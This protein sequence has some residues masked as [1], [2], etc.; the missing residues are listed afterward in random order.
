MSRFLN[1][2]DN[3]GMLIKVQW[4]IIAGLLVVTAFAIDGLRRAPSSMDLHI[5]PDLTNGAVVHPGEV[6]P[7]NVY[8]FTLA[9]WQQVNRW[10]KNGQTDFGTQ[11]FAMSPYLTPSC[12]DHLTDHMNLRAGRG[13]LSQRTRVLSEMVDR[14]FTPDR[15][16]RLARGVWLVT[17]D[18]EIQETV[19]GQPV[20]QVYVRWPLR[21]IRYR[22]DP[23]TNA[24]GLAI[25]CS[26]KENPPSVIDLAAEKAAAAGAADA[27]AEKSFSIIK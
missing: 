2:L 20:K 10:A 17:L 7:P 15:V 22:F 19:H 3:A 4:A 21:V 27:P 5:P 9:I 8:A 24:Y 16:Q 26:P 6:P 14:S 11:I 25:D 13:E 23:Q 1:A 12:Q 18:T